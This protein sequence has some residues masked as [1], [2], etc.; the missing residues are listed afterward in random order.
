M[1][2][3][4]FRCADAARD[5]D[6][7]MVGTA[8]PAR[9]WL[10]IEHPGPWAPEAFAES[11]IER[12]VQEQLRSAAGAS[13]A[14]ILLVRRP[15]RADPQ[16]G[17]R[18]WAVVDHASGV[19]SVW[20]TWTEDGDL[21]DAALA[22]DPERAPVGPVHAAEEPVLLVCTHGRHDTCCAIRGRPV[23]AALAQRWPD[24]TWECSHVGGDRF[25]AN[26]VLLPDG[27]YYGYLDAESAVRVVEQHLAGRVDADFL[28]GLST[29][30]PVVQAAVVEALRQWG[31]VGARTFRSV[32]LE[33]LDD[34]GW[35][36]EL[37]GQPGAGVPDRVGLT[38]RRATRAAAQL[39]CRAG[40]PAASTTYE[41]VDA[42]VLGPTSPDAA[43]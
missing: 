3:T 32:H 9:R 14:R 20:G 25:A 21:L 27:A 17:P 23:A 39:T 33:A 31:P 24:W 19:P 37:A 26:V 11:G 2:D 35:R 43:G 10:L 13:G 30:P 36:V 34:G 8:A 1:T 22:L 16:R 28:R 18:A 41:V 15:G 7:P 4:T 42:R 6:D 5:R 12:G 40:G 29:E 38:V